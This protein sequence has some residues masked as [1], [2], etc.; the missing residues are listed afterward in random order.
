MGVGDFLNIDLGGGQ[1]PGTTAGCAGPC[2]CC[3][4][5]QAEPPGRKQRA[6]RAARSAGMLLGAFALVFVIAATVA[7]W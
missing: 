2:D 4:Y 3:D 6:L 1:A 5:P 7:D